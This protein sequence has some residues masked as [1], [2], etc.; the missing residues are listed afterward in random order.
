MLMPNTTSN[1][2]P[3]ICLHFLQSALYFSDFLHLTKHD[4]YGRM[5]FV[6]KPFSNGEKVRFVCEA[7]TRSYEVFLYALSGYS[8]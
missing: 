2:Y 7:E 6:V 4:K 1:I 3:I 5:S 8:F